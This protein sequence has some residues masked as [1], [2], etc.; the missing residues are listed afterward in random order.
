[1]GIPCEII[2][3]MLWQPAPGVRWVR[4]SGSNTCHTWRIKVHWVHHTGGHTQNG[5][6][7][8]IPF[9]FCPRQRSAGCRLVHLQLLQCLWLGNLL[10]NLCLDHTHQRKDLQ[11]LMQH[12][13]ADVRIAADINFGQ[14]R[15]HNL[16]RRQSILFVGG[17]TASEV[18][19]TTAAWWLAASGGQ[20]NAVGRGQ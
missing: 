3:E 17:L 20:L 10:L 9:I 16:F 13:V 8:G 14:T 18:K 1:M 11:S 19:G 15:A 6:P 4:L 2:G 12:C 7:V 5:E